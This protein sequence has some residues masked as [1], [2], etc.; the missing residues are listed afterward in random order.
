MAKLLA[1]AG[2][3]EMARA[4]MDQGA[5]V[6]YVGP[7]G[8]SRR[9]YECELSDAEIKVVIDY[10]A[11]SGKEVRVAMNTYPSPFEMQAFLAKVRQYADWGATGFIVTDVGAISLLRR[12]VPETIIHVSIGSGITNKHDAE[13]YRV[14][15]ADAIILPYR[16]AAREITQ[17]RATTDIGLEVFLFE[18]V[19][20]GIICPGKCIMS[21]YLK[22][23]DWLEAEG[24]HS[25]HGSANRGAKEC[26][27][28]CQTPWDYNVS[29]SDAF[30]VRLRRDAQLMLAQLPEYIGLGIEYFKLSG[31]ERPVALIRDLVR[32][33]RKVIDGIVRGNQTDMHA[34][35]EELLVLRKR[36]VNEKRKRIDTLMSRASDYLDSGKCPTQS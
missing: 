36:W 16:W 5:D 34:H 33:Y 32:F 21:S 17:T 10:A 26:Y 3:V 27:R 24:E 31:R 22:F 14:L 20:T 2:T 6:V 12:V 7:L 35:Q 4:A 28:V 13:F 18:P 19:R 23:R 8:W 11:A 9:T 1:P 15:G 30:D 25:F 29:G